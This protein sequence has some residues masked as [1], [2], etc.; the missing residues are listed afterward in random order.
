MKSFPN[1]GVSYMKYSEY[2]LDYDL[3]INLYSKVFLKSAQPFW[4]SDLL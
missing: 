4:V 1:S 3:A 2:K